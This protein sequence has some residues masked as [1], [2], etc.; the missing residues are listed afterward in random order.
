MLRVKGMTLKEQLA[1]MKKNPELALTTGRPLN[2]EKPASKPDSK[3][4]TLKPVEETKS[5]PVKA[6]T[7]SKAKKT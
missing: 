4:S 3:P 7:G 5:E 1:E 2:L 6:N